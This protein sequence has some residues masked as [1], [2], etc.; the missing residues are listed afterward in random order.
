[1]FEY[2][3]DAGLAGTLTTTVIVQMPFAASV[4]FENV[5][6]VSFVAGAKVGDPHPEVENVAGL[7]TFIAPGEVG[8]GSVKLTPEMVEEVGFVMVKVRV[9]T[10]PA[11]VELGENTFENVKL[12]GSMIE[13]M[14]EEAEKSL[15]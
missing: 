9:D 7:A 3:P 15:L 8:K 11:L 13:A 1:M 10:P 5:R 6:V 14:R 4:P 12:E 2:V